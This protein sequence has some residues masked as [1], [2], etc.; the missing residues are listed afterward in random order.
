MPKTA[1][2]YKSKYGYTQQYAK[3]LAAALEADLFELKSNTCPA[4]QGYSTI[5]FG[6]GLYAGGIGGMP[7]FCE[8]FREHNGA[9][10]I[11]FTTG[12]SSTDNP[13]MFTAIINRNLT[14]EMH[15]KVKVFHM[16]G[17][18]DYKKLGLLHRV[19]MWMMMRMLISKKP[20]ELTEDD[21]GFMAA[22]GKSVSFLD[23]DSIEPIL[24]YICPQE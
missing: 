19:M 3:W 21:K 12:V 4:L 6:G 14:P 1:V 20:G 11:L 23:E 18:I 16:R 13:D 5:I 7:V 9:S 15:A 2:V 22:Y 24:S 17:G 10:F 8:I